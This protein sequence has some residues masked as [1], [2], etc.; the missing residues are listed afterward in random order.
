MN[1]SLSVCRHVRISLPLIVVSFVVVDRAYE[2]R[3][4]S[5][6]RSAAANLRPTLAPKGRGGLDGR[7]G[8]HSPRP[9]FGLI[10]GGRASTSVLRPAEGRPEGRC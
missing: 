2:P 4:T 8:E 5:P 9:D 3:R 7:Y 6:A 1:E 10:R